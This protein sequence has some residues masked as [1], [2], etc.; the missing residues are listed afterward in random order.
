MYS[1]CICISTGPGDDAGKKSQHCDSQTGGFSAESF[2]FL[3]A[4]K[5]LLSEVSCQRRDKLIVAQLNH[6]YE[7][8]W[9]LLF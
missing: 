4:L 6:F 9:A 8:S 1:G 3:S 5:C 7:F 2:A